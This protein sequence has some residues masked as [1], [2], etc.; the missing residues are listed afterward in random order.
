[1][2]PRRILETAGFITIAAALHVS[3][4]AFLLPEQVQQGEAAEAHA[5]PAALAAGG[6][7]VQAMVSDWETPPE[8]EIPPDM[9]GP[10]PA[11]EPQPLPV[12][13]E[14]PPVQMALAP[15]LMAMPDP[16]PARPNLPE[17][18]APHIAPAELDPPVTEEPALTLAASARPER[19][20]DRQ[21]KPHPTRQQQPERQQ[22]PRET[23]APT[24]PA[25]QRAGQGGQSQA[26]AQGGGGGGL[27]A[28]QQAS[29]VSQWGGQIR[30]CINRRVSAPRG[31][32]QG[33]R[34][35]LAL[36]VGR[37]GRIQ[38]VGVAGSSGQP[39]LDQ[40]AVRGAQRAGRC[41]GA[42]AGLTDASYSFQLPIS[43]D[44]R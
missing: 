26:S 2:A 23:P 28:Q 9:A 6:E 41:P 35:V 4:A 21:P 11:P 30:S 7:A 43:L 8:L 44:V 40:A 32:R 17:P 5:A 16:S 37:D 15:P 33:G 27:S 13:P 3:A 25:P 19:R 34:V 31:L 38:G 14:A 36:T 39:P 29:L 42:P 1:M 22:A 12:A 20:P 18:P 24:Q 10:Q